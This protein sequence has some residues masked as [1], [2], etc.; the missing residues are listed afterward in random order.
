MKLRFIVVVL[1][2]LV[3]ACGDSGPQ[4]PGSFRASVQAT[5]P[6]AGAAI[7]DV[8]G[9]GIQGFQGTGDTR[10]FPALIDAAAGVHRVI[11][12]SASGVISFR[13]QVEQVELGAPAVLVVDAADM[14]NGP[15]G[16]AGLEVQITN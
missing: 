13:I 15:R 12:V 4:G 10:V 9:P 14:Q 6:A 11:A 2:A 5:G 1:A 7:L 8:T 3:S 16:P